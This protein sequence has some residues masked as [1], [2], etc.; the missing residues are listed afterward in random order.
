VA[1]LAVTVILP[2][3]SSAF[4]TSHCACH[5]TALLCRPLALLDY[6]TQDLTGDYG[7]VGTVTLIVNPVNLRPTANSFLVNVMEGVRTRILLTGADTDEHDHILRG[8]VVNLPALGDVYRV[9]EALSDYAKMETSNFDVMDSRLIDFDPLS[10]T[11]GQTVDINYTVTDSGLLTS[12]VGTVTITIVSA[13]SPPAPDTLTNLYTITFLED[14]IDGNVAGQLNSLYPAV[15]TAA[16]LDRASIMWFPLD[17]PAG[18][19]SRTTL[20]TPLTGYGGATVDQLYFTGMGNPGLNA[21][22]IHLDSTNGSTLAD[23]GRYQVQINLQ[24]VLQAAVANDQ[25]VVCFEDAFVGIHLNG[26]DDLLPQEGLFYSVSTLPGSGEL[27]QTLNGVVPT[28][29]PLSATSL[30]IPVI[31]NNRLLYLPGPNFDGSDLFQYL[32]SDTASPISG[33]PGSVTL[34]VQPV[35]DN[36]VALGGN[37]LTTEGGVFPL[38]LYWGN[39][40]PDSPLSQLFVEVLALPSRGFLSTS[41]DSMDQVTVAPH[42]VSVVGSNATIWYHSPPSE[43]SLPE[44]SEFTRFPYVA[45]DAVSCSG[46]VYARIY[47]SNINDPPQ[48]VDESLTAFEDTD[49]LYVFPEA[50]VVDP[51]GPEPIRYTITE[52]P[53]RGKLYQSFFTDEKGNPVRSQPIQSLPPPG[54]AVVLNVIYAPEPGSF[55]YSDTFSYLARDDDGALSPTAAVMN[56]TVLPLNDAPVVRNAAVPVTQGQRAT[57]D[58]NVYTSDV[59]MD[60]I[61]WRIE[62]GPSRGSLQAGSST[63]SSFPVDLPSSVV[64]YSPGVVTGIIINPFANFTWTAR[65][66]NISAVAT[67]SLGRQREE[68]G[69]SFASCVG[70]L[71]T[72]HPSPIACGLF[73]VNT[74]AFLVPCDPP[75]CRCDSEQGSECQCDLG[76]NRRGCS[77]GGHPLR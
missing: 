1:A 50:S 60:P 70:V 14:V 42:T 18:T 39:L 21:F 49:F 15:F 41:A 9:G 53:M 62:R 52:L 67:I 3:S 17:D 40:P 20:G 31:N 73:Y 32:V 71:W 12:A 64:F 56:I 19:L 29:L 37:W 59:E 76:V 66:A 16:T 72:S 22:R 25:T 65:D 48:L 63:L 7:N 8:T 54:D 6:S 10:A 24:D 51:D 13:T 36:P 58:L 5:A 34:V 77:R 33:T 46:T 11:V 55:G 2:A 75:V 45:C 27:Y 74:N 44:G 69:V 61:T 28:G 47:V 26:T 30:P 4:V 23:L 38:D 43:S 35:D 68:R 57:I